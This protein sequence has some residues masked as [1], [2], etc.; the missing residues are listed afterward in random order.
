MCLISYIDVW[1]VFNLNE[2]SI[3]K[4]LNLNRDCCANDIE[5]K[6]L[7]TLNRKIVAILIWYTC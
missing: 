3:L 1:W 2:H 7:C 5:G 6:N 4:I